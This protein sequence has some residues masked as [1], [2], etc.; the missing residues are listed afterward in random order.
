MNIN[1]KYIKQI[2][3]AIE[4]E[5][6]FEDTSNFSSCTTKYPLPL[7]TVSIISV[8]NSRSTV[9]YILK[10]MWD[11]GYIKKMIKIKH[12]KPY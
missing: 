8:N 11:S 12:I 6:K 9:V 7:V 3:Y 10:F 5:L 1:L 2:N 4:H